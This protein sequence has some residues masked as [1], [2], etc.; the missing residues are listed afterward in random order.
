[1]EV[2]KHEEEH[3]DL[4]E[5]KQPKKQPKQN[6][7]KLDQKPVAQLQMVANVRTEEEGMM[8]MEEYN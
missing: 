5:V 6:K 8:N 4:E 1:M 7:R 2:E 3:K